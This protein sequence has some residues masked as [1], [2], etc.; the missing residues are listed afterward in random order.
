M[1]FLNDLVAKFL[2]FVF[3]PIEPNR[4]SGHRRRTFSDTSECVEE[5]TGI[6]LDVKSA[7]QPTRHVK[8]TQ[9]RVKIGRRKFDYAS[10]TFDTVDNDEVSCYD[11]TET[12]PL[13]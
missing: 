5:G 7:P 4:G 6:K 11:S 3:P 1:V 13:N 10:C 8:P 9:S 2:D 12:C